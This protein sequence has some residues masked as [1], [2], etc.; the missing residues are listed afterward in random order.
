MKHVGTA[1]TPAPRRYADGDSP[2]MS[3]NVRL[4]VPRLV[5]PTARQ[6]SVTLRSV[7]AQQE[8]RAFDAAAL[9]VAVGRLAE[10]A[11]GRSG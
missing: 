7:V 3:R 6:M 4:N 8:H 11:R 5:K 2:T 1:T 10:G 9:E